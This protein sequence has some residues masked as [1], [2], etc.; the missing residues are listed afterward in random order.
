VLEVA[1]SPLAEVYDL[2]MLDLDGVVY[3]GAHAIPGVPERLA[4]LRSL[5]VHVAFVT[6]NA[7][8][9]PAEVAG[10]LR[11]LG[12]GAADGDVVTSAQAAAH[13]LA[14]EH[15]AGARIFLLGGDGL[16]QALH[17]EGLVPVTSLDDRPVAVVSGYGPDVPWRRLMQGAVL[18]RDGLPW[19]ASNTD[20]TFPTEYGVGPGHGVQVRM[21]SDF[22]GVEP[23][24][25][26]KPERALLDETVRRVGGIRPLMI[27]DRLDTDIEGGH[28][29]GVDTLCVLTGVTGLGELVTAPPALRPTYLAPDLEGLFEP[30]AVPV[31]EA[32][33]FAL[34]GWSARVDQGR[35]AITGSGAVSD[36]WRVAVAASWAHVD[37]HGTAVDITQID[38]PAGPAAGPELAQVKPVGAPGAGRPGGTDGR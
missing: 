19:V 12:I 36:W 10:H 15:G 26:G 4:R 5:G 2:A 38:P 23:T 18:I 31:A 16:E 3:V 22:T 35:L 9:P 37:E 13:L 32:G 8:R 29:A 28:N 25:A 20:H 24:I 33:G 7:S 17:A 27:G 14:L 30:H 21:L 11:E 1:E 6:N 34:G